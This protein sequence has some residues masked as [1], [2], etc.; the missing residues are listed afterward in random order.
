MSK[1]YYGLFLVGLPS[2]LTLSSC[3]PMNRLPQDKVT[4]KTEYSVPRQSNLSPLQLGTVDDVIN[5]LDTLDREGGIKAVAE[6]VEKEL[7]PGRQIIYKGR[8]DNNIETVAIYDRSVWRLDNQGQISNK[9]ILLPLTNEKYG[10]TE[11][12]GLWSR[13]RAKEPFV[14]RLRVW[15]KVEKS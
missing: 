10:E 8:I 9:A 7:Q 6:W 14:L 15:R 13:P 12:F 2:L 1:I 11:V 3:N 4:T 5:R